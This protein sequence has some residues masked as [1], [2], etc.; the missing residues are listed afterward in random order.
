MNA[1]FTRLIETARL[2]RRW[3]M[4]NRS[5]FNC[6]EDL[7][8]MCAIASGY[9]HRLLNKSGIDSFLCVNNEH[10]FVLAGDYIVDVTATQFGLKPV[11]VVESE[12]AFQ[13]FWFIDKKFKTP[14]HLFEHQVDDGWPFDQ[15]VLVDNNL[16]KQM[17]A[18]KNRVDK[19]QCCEV[20][21]PMIED[22]ETLHFFAKSY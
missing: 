6:D 20:N 17:E 3:A 16:A 7:A 8:G 22:F 21:K 2:A 12:N 11:C 10:C 13:D 15:M 1:S 5:K 14:E 4:R 18:I 9:L 19:L